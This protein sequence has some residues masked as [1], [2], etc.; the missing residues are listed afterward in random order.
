MPFLFFFFFFFWLL[1]APSFFFH[2]YFNI[3][4]H[5][6]IE[7]IVFFSSSILD[8]LFLVVSIY[9]SYMHIVSC[10][11]QTFVCLTF[12]RH[13]WKISPRCWPEMYV[14]VPGITLV[15]AGSYQATWVGHPPNHILHVHKH[16]NQYYYYYFYYYPSIHSFYAL[17]ILF[18]AFCSFLFS[19]RVPFPLHYTQPFAFPH[20]QAPE[21]HCSDSPGLAYRSAWH[22]CHCGRAWWWPDRRKYCFIFFYSHSN[23][24]ELCLIH[25]LFINIYHT[26]YIFINFIII[27]INIFSFLQG[28]IK[29]SINIPSTLFHSSLAALDA[30]VANVPRVVFH[31]QL[32]QIRG[33]SCASAYWR[34]TYNENTAGQP[35][36]QQIY[37]LEGGFSEWAR[38]YGTDSTVTDAFRPELYR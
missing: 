24:F 26:Y 27:I 4:S 25:Y 29:S 5:Y 28:H 34:H 37:V 19:R 8:I 35:G 3:I 2:L 21:D 16:S 31:C 36:Q 9:V 30:K 13:I 11:K 12:N 15:S 17:F 7:Y 20:V 18:I 10:V 33:P 22:C 23:E 1:F 32:S 38:V 6:F 14:A